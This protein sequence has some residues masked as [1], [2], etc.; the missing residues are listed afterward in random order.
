VH[1]STT[2]AVLRSLIPVICPEEAWPLGDAIVEHMALTIGAS[3]AILQ[4]MIGTGM[5]AYD[6][7]A[8]PRFL[9]RAHKLDPARAET[10]Y[11]SW[12]HGIT[13]LHVQLARA[14]NQLMSLSCYEQPQMMERVG[15]RP[16]PWIDE[17]RKKRL[18]VF[19]DDVAKQELQVL[20]PDPL[21]TTSWR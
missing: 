7:G 17:V 16:A 2:R 3:P 4:K 13:P 8:V 15:F 10:Y 11:A 6:L 12:E 18:S 20:A 9:R 1:S 21:R 5:T 14:I 19:K